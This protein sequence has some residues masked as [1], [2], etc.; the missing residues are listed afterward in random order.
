MPP[1]LVS[2]IILAALLLMC[3]AVW[4]MAR[5]RTTV[6]PMRPQRS[7]RLVSSGIFSYSRN[8]IYLGDALLIVAAGLYWATWLFLPVLAVFVYYIT[9]FQILPEERALKEKFGDAFEQY[10]SRTRRW[11]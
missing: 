5:A 8:P 2:A 10:C 6:N 1:W 9:R 3:L 7:R 4:E 11:V